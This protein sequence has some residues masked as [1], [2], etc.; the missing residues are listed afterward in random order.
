MLVYVS[1]CVWSGEVRAVSSSLQQRSQGA[2]YTDLDNDNTWPVKDNLLQRQVQRGTSEGRKLV[3][4]VSVFFFNSYLSL[5][6]NQQGNGNTKMLPEE[7]QNTDNS[8]LPASL[9]KILLHPDC[10]T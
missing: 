8:F 10:L 3:V 5:E 6:I 1:T 9:E 7:N 4:I 2:Y